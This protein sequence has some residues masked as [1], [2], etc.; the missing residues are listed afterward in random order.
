M[1]IDLE[2]GELPGDDEPDC[3]KVHAKIMMDDDVPDSHDLPP[4]NYGMFFPNRSG[5]LSA[6]L[7]DDLKVTYHCIDGFLVPEEVLL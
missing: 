3:L 4:G 2:I 7:S 1:K 6:C 5:Y